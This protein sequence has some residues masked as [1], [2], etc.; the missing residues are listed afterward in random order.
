MEACESLSNRFSNTVRSFIT[1][2]SST[3]SPLLWIIHRPHQEKL[4]LCKVHSS[5]VVNGYCTTTPPNDKLDCHVI[6]MAL[7]RAH[8]A[9]KA[10][11]SPLIRSCLYLI[12]LGSNYSLTD[13]RHLNIPDL[14]KTFLK[15]PHFTMS[16]KVGKVPGS[17]LLS[18][19]K[20]L[21]SIPSS[22]Q[23]L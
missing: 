23:I 22:F 13:T 12:E 3:V 11:E 19:P 8:T 5:E 17:V 1:L 14:R 9:S 20:I 10:Q 15:M 2:N 16:K 4:R 21:V 7:S 6:I 18:R